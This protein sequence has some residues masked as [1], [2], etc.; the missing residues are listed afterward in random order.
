MESLAA[1]SYYFITKRQ[2]ETLW[3]GEAMRTFLE[4]FINPRFWSAFVG[5]SFP[6]LGGIIA[7]GY[8][9]AKEK[10]NDYIRRF[11]EGK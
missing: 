4:L 10:I 6:L 2:S 1:Y 9:L 11:K 3:K 8:L 7:C 5:L